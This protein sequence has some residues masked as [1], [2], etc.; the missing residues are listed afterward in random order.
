[1][2]G[3]TMDA[4]KKK[5]AA[6]RFEKEAAYEKAE[7]LEQQLLRQKSVNEQVGLKLRVHPPIY[8]LQR[9]L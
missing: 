7:C 2:A 1:M 8:V 5:M 4:I 6:M 3:N 9:C